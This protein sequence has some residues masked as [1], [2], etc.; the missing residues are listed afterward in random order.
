MSS[1]ED[2]LRAVQLCI[3][4]DARIG[5]TLRQLGYPTKNALLSWHRQCGQHLDPP[6]TCVSRGTRR[7]TRSWPSGTTAR[8]AA[9]SRRRSG[10]RRLLRSTEGRDVLPARLEIH[11]TRGVRRCLGRMHPQLQRRAD[12]DLTRLP[13]PRRASPAPGDHR[14]TSPGFWPH[15]RFGRRSSRDLL[16]VAVWSLLAAPTPASSASRHPNA[17]A[18]SV[19]TTPG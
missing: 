17:Q 5:L 15:P 7:R 4:L 8:T 19:R 6:A 12:Q 2:R 1:C 16:P 3:K 11:N 9:A 18:R 13:Q 14:S 10:V